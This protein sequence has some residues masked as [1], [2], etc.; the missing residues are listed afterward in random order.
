[1]RIVLTFRYVREGGRLLSNSWLNDVLKARR[2][3]G[4]GLG[5]D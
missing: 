5:C 3:C 1:V 2:D 4:S